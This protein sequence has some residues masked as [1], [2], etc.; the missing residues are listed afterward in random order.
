MDTNTQ[1]GSNL[2]LN[3]FVAPGRGIGA[4]KVMT[5]Q[6]VIGKILGA[7][8]YPGTLN[9]VLSDPLIL[10]EAHQLDIKGKL[11]GIQGAINGMPCLVYRF[12]GAPL[13]VVEIVSS[14]H[15]RNSLGLK[16]G[17]AVEISLPRKN[18]AVPAPWRRRLWELFYKGR[19]SAYYDDH[20]QKLFV[21]RGFK[22]FH[23]KICQSK[24]EFA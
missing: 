7:T 10:K 14:A 4:D 21:S 23:K 18:T 12:H 5:N 24:K 8:P 16:D 6:D 17:Q 2:I 3:G 11:F 19:P 9:V 20:L 13:H 1:D 15:L 22:F